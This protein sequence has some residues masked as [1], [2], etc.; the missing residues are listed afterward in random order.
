MTSTRRA[1]SS[2]GRNRGNVTITPAQ[3]AADGEGSIN[4]HWRT[5]FLQELAATSNVRT[6]AAKAGVSVSRVYKVRRA[7]ADFAAAWRAALFEGYEH[8]EMEVLACLRGQD[9]ARK[10]DGAN[11]IRL[12]A[13][14]R[15]TV[16]E[17]RARRGGQDEAAVFAALDRKLDAIRS[18]R[19]AY[20]AQGSA[21]EA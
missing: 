5:Y 16:A 1:P 6:S 21:D 17:E 18:R 11:A 19:L 9:T 7:Q 2:R 15:T 3:K 20:A 14:H 12:L 10:I 8:L 13:A 4:K